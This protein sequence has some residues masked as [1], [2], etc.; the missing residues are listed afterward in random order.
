MRTLARA[1]H[2]EENQLMSLLRSLA[3]LSFVAAL[4]AAQPARACTAFATT[5]AAGTLV[6][7]SFE[8]QTG[9]G[10]AV[11]NERGRSRMPLVPGHVGWTAR[12]ASLSFTTVGPGFPVSGLNEAGL[13]IESLVDFSVQ[14]ERAPRA[15]LLSGLELVQYGLDRF[16]TVDELAAFSEREG[17]SQLGVGL[18]FF[19]CERSGRCAVIE[20]SDAGLAVSYLPRKQAQALANRPLAEDRASHERGSWLSWLAPAPGPGSSAARYA[21]AIEGLGAVQTPQ[22]AFR[23]L[24]RLRGHSTRWQLVWDLAQAS[25]HFRAERASSSLR[26]EPSL[27]CTGAPRVLALHALDGQR[28]TAWNVRDQL[29]AEHSILAQLGARDPGVRRLAA[30][31][32]A[33]TGSSRCTAME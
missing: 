30:A 20:S 25:V 22:D 13:V 6:A 17:F 18:H 2:D 12:Y 31:V 24:E 11:Q 3:A 28:F 1:E 15:G 32:A 10:W 16:A 21:T 8:W 9:E 33:A 26:V 5:T 27:A 14:P 29:R 4:G 7:K 19:A 23:L